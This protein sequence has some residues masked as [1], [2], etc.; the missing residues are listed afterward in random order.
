MYSKIFKTITTMEVKKKKA[1]GVLAEMI[2]NMDVESLA[3]TRQKM[4]EEARREDFF[5]KKAK[6]Y[7]QMRESCGVNDPVYLDEI[8]DAFYSGM[9][10]AYGQSIILDEKEI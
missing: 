10:C 2:K 6:E 1:T 9:C 4:I 7:R 8:E 5:L 3:Q